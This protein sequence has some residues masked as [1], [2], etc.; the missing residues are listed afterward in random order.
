MLKFDF[1]HCLS[2]DAALEHV[3][4]GLG[5]ALVVVIHYDLS[6]GQHPHHIAPDPYIFPLFD[7]VVVDLSPE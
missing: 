4:C 7:T 3:A 1:A 6:L 2:P 5:A